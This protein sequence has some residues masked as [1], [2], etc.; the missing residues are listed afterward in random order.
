MGAKLLE[1]FNKV[2]TSPEATNKIIAEAVK[3][4]L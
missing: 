3:D 4:V 2:D 1:E